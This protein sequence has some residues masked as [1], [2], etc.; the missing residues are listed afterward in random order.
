M[1][2]LAENQYPI[3]PKLG[4]C[5][6]HVTINPGFGLIQNL[7]AHHKKG[8]VLLETYPYEFTCPI[9]KQQGAL[10][11]ASVGTF[12]DVAEYEGFN[13]GCEGLT[14]PEPIARCRSR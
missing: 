14:S 8:Q 7:L 10:I 1:E 5:G 4:L 9:A 6:R 12:P 3:I 2:F 13:C 11:A